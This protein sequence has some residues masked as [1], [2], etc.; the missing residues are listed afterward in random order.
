MLHASSGKG[1]QIKLLFAF[2]LSPAIRRDVPE[3]R[4]ARIDDGCGMPFIEIRNAELPRELAAVRKLFR[5]YADS[6]S[7]DLCFQN[8]EAELAGLPGKY[9]PPKGRLLLACK[10]AEAVGCVA[11]RPLEENA[12]EMK[13]LY[14]QPHV[15]GEKLGRRLVDRICQE[16]RNAGYSRI[17]LDTLPDMAKAIRLYLDVG[18]QPIDPYVF[19]PISGAIFLALDL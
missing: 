13:R 18:F 16:A 12:C 3:R 10:D 9:C 7:T 17:C 6:L 5:E 1:N 11:L 14:V 4:V 2:V 15:R 8:F 19:N